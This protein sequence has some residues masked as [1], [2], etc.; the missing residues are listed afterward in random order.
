MNHFDLIIIGAGSGNM[1]LTPDFDDW[2]VAIVEEGAFGGTCLNRGCIPSKMFAYAAEVAHVAHRGPEY[3]VNTR[4]DGVDWP[5]IRDRVFNRIDPIA[6]AGKQY[7]EGLGNVSVFGTRGIFVGPKELQVGDKT[8][9]GDTIV[10]GAGAR[11]SIP[12]ITGLDTVPYHTSDDIMRIEALPDR[13]VVL[14]G[15]FIAAELGYVFGAFGVDVEFIV[16]GPRMLRGEDHDISDWFTEQ[17]RRRYKVRTGASLHRVSHGHEGFRVGGSDDVGTFETGG[18]MML[19]ATGRKPNADALNVEAAGVA[20]DDAGYVVVD[21]HGR[22][23]VEGVWAIGDIAHPDQLKHLA[24]ATTRVVAHNIV[25][26]DDLREVTLGALPH[27]VFAHPQVAS[28][29]LTEREVVDAGVPYTKSIKPYGAAAYGWAMEDQDSICKLLAHSDTRR[30]LGA[31]IM[32]PLA[33]TL[34]QQLVQGMRFGR[35]VDE[36]ASEQYYI[37]PAPTEVV[38]Q[39]LLDL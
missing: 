37:H 25:H 17:Y 26:P 28:V 19:V 7:R 30:L 33:A 9:T 29:G 15:G 23:N 11:P 20:V 38:E 32:G 2:R 39:A 21:A 13:L 8:I 24:N 27:A 12:Q 22:T 10:L 6:H 4:L 3:G 31:H 35:T 16:R 18:D 5:A 36:M 14:G 1:L 34:I